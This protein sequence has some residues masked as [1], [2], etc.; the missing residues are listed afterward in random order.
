M[1]SSIGGSESTPPLYYAVAWVWSRV[2][3]HG[4]VGLRSLSALAGTL[5]VPV[6]Y[7]AGKEL[8]SRRV[9]VVI[10]ALA[11]FNPLL[12]WYSQEVRMYEFAAL[13]GLLALLMQLRAIRDPTRLLN[14][15]APSS[16]ARKISVCEVELWIF[17]MADSNCADAGACGAFPC[18]AGSSSCVV[19]VIRSLRSSSMPRWTSPILGRYG[20]L[21]TSSMAAAATI[22]FP[23]SAPR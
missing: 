23:I 21:L 19:R 10:A 3:G 2:F 14:W 9:A 20:A 17:A 6:A 5:F 11:A 4:E 1:L 7:A 18:S 15:A 22:L 16:S 8:A 12:I 13:F